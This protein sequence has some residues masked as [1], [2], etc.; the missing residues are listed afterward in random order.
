MQDGIKILGIDPGFGRMG[1][2][3]VWVAGGQV[4]PLDFG[5]ITTDT[6]DPHE[7]RL[8]AIAQDLSALFLEHQPQL[9]AIEKLFF[10]QNSTTAMKVAEARGVALLIAAQ[11]GIPV[12]EFTPAQVKKALTCDGKAGKAAMQRMVKDFLNLPAVPKPDDVADALAI[13][14]TAAG[15]KW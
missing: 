9:V 5:V 4:T 1:F 7:T 2:G 12:V 3:C 8:L 13:A 10:A 6:R 11:C 14:I 15:K